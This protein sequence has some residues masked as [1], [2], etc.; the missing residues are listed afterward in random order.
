MHRRIGIISD[1]HGLVRPEAV[2]ALVGVDLI[3]HAGDIGSLAV[4]EELRRLAPVRAVRGNVDRGAW[5]NAFPSTEVVECGECLL[6]VLHEP[7]E[8][9][10]DPV[11]AGFSAAKTTPARTE[12]HDPA[13]PASRPRS[14]ASP[15]A[16][17]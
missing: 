13:P 3:V 9:D 6:Y 8:L 17:W 12:A 16:R 5:A 2:Q 10:L 14:A 1:T 15:R 7:D 4:I 11:A